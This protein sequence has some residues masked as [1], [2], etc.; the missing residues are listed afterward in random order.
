[1][2]FSVSFASNHPGRLFSCLPLAPEEDRAETIRNCLNKP[3]AG[4]DSIHGTSFASVL[5]WT[6]QL[7]QYK[8][9]LKDAQCLAKLWEQLNIFFFSFSGGEW[10]ESIAPTFCWVS[11]TARNMDVR[12]VPS[13][14]VNGL[15]RNT[16]V[17]GKH[18]C[19]FVFFYSA[20]PVLHHKLTLTLC[21]PVAGA[22]SLISGNHLHMGANW[23]LVS[24]P[25]AIWWNPEGLWPVAG[26]S[27]SLKN[28]CDE[29][30]CVYFET[31]FIHR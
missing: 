5:C 3:S 20:W 18:S 25:R 12:I 10:D 30:C 29:L 9:W 17:K 14:F 19:L 16:A 13:L 21:K 8:L 22:A 27:C 2:K 26:L 11:V 4:N 15:K 31:V 24:G 7:I 23:S 6:V 28:T 1:M